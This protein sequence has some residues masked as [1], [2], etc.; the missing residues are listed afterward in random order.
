MNSRFQ[1]VEN[2]LPFIPAALAVAAALPL[3]LAGAGLPLDDAYIFRRYA[4]NLALGHGFSFNPGETSFG[5]TSF[6]WPVLVS[7]WLRLF[8]ASAYLYVVQALGILAFAGTALLAGLITQELTRSRL[9]ALA[10]GLLV[11][12]SPAQFM[13][14]VSGM[15]TP[16]F[17]FEAAL[18]VWLCVRYEFR[19][20][21][22]GALCG[23][24][25]LTRPEGL[26]LALLVPLAF[27]LK[28]QASARKLLAFIISF[29]VPTIPYLAWVH[30]HTGNFLPTTYLGKIMAADPNSLDRPLPQKI[31]LAFFS[32]GD[33]WIKLTAPFPFLGFLL[34]ATALFLGLSLL[35]DSLEKRVTFFPGFFLLVC[36]I[37]LA[38]AYG[39]VA[40]SGSGFPISPIFILLGLALDLDLRKK[41]ESFSPVLF[42]LIG[43]LFLPA[44]YGFGFPVSPP[45][46]GYYHRYIAVV[47]LSLAIGGCA[48][49]FR[50]YQ[51]MA[52]RW[53]ALKNRFIFPVG[54]A[55]FAL[56]LGY[57]FFPQ[58]QEGRKVF[59]HEVSLNEGLRR[60]AAEWIREHTAKDAKV[61]VGYTGLGVVGGGCGRYVYDLGALINPDIFTY[62]RDT[63]PLTEKR[64]LRVLDYIR[65]RGVTW[66]VTFHYPYHPVPDPARSPGFQEMARLGSPGEPTS[67]YE[68]IRIYRIFPQPNP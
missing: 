65:D 3:A 61:L 6:L 19:P 13:N 54:F 47:M 38:A 63:K 31:V 39:L 2:W 42:V 37:F 35:R 30:Y 64:W 11:V 23:L 68:Q 29:G 57:L 1:A 41:R 55:L 62:Y 67:P 45:F 17:G 34:L 53:P 18:L 27:I 52:G 21:L 40:S 46:G 10:A 20:I 12:A 60:E 16:L 24:L 56:Y 43:L 44:S 28:R 5:C 14:A 51:G 50:I 36:L 58:W 26:G 48:G 59:I 4:E 25:F 66:Y 49:L 33:G 15:E 9:F 32:L 22:L 8:G 7:P